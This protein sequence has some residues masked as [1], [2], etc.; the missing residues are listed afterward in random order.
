[1]S[2]WLFAAEGASYECQVWVE[3]LGF[4]FFWSRVVGLLLVA[5]YGLPDVV[6]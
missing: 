4:V 1:M 5:D 6:I 3:M 2:S